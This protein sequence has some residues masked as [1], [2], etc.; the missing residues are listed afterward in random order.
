[1]QG[2]TSCD[3]I[4]V[5]IY[6]YICSAL[7]PRASRYIPQ[8]WNYIIAIIWLL[9]PQSPSDP[10]HVYEAHAK[11]CR[12]ALIAGADFLAPRACINDR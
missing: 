12:R 7:Q 5:G 2:K 4:C 6:H 8:R 3:S 10:K 9:Q 1:M 11:Y